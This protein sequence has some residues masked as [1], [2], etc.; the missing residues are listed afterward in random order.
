MNQFSSRVFSLHAKFTYG[1]LIGTLPF[2]SRIQSALCAL[3]ITRVV[4]L[5][6]ASVLCSHTVTIATAVFTQLREEFIKKKS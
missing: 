2:L 3:L 5:L 6:H 4:S 1:F